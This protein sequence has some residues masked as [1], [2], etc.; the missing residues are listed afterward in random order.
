[1]YTERTSEYTI[2]RAHEYE[3]ST[4]MC[5]QIW[6]EGSYMDYSSLYTFIDNC[7]E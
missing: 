2:H 7:V 5:N 1:M 3:R 4:K 6:N